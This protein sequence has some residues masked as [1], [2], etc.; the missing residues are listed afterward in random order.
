MF[1]AL[2]YLCF[3]SIFLFLAHDGERQW[4]NVYYGPAKMISFESAAEIIIV[5]LPWKNRS[6][7]NRIRTSNLRVNIN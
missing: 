2:Y 4:K 7:N 5:S 3:I 6:S 1:R